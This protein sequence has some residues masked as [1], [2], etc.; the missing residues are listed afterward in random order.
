MSAVERVREIVEP[1][2]ESSDSSLYDIEHE[3]GILRIMVDRSGGIDVDTIGHL[4]EQISAALDADDPLPGQRYLL[5]VTSPGIERKLRRPEHYLQQVG[6][7]VNVKLKVAVDGVRR[8]E[9]R[10]EAADDTGVTISIERPEGSSRHAF[11]YDEIESARTI[12]QWP[13]GAFEKPTQANSRSRSSQ[14]PSTKNKSTNKK[15]STR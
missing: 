10:L 3:S 7:D 14:S 5:E 11:A 13:G 6:A 2:L 15:A 4:S 8:V 9:G 1:I 12:F